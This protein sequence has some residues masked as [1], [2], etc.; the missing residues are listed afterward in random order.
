[1]SEYHEFKVI[2]LSK[3]ELIETIYIHDDFFSYLWET[4]PLQ[5][6]LINNIPV[7]YKQILY[8]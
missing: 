7:F 5:H 3:N 4:Q 1:M 6:E 8:I 2:N